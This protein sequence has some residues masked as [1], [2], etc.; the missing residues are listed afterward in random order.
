MIC[1]ASVM[2]L[3][4]DSH[5]EYRRRHDAIWPDMVEQLKAHGAH[6]YSIF[7]NE[8][9]SE[10]FAYVEIE[11]EQRWAAMADTE[12]CRRWWAMMC[13]IMPSHAD[14]SPIACDLTQV[15]YLD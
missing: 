6:H 15:F 4:P 10:L 5:E 2:Q 3:K 14:N 13:D 1:K 9:T 12:V 8:K 11:D 7:L